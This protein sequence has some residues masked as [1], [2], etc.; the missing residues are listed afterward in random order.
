M[1]EWGLL[2]VGL[3]MS[4]QIGSGFAGREW[5]QAKTN[6]H[7]QQQ[8]IHQRQQNVASEYRSLQ[9]LQ[10]VNLVCQ[11]CHLVMLRCESDA[12]LEFS[13]I[14]S[15]FMKTTTA[16]M[17]PPS[18]L[19]F[20]CFDNL[21]ACNLAYFGCIG[22]STPTLLLQLILVI[23]HTAII[24]STHLQCTVAFLLPS[25]LRQFTGP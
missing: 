18:L 10:V 15:C 4:S 7:Q 21:A 8:Q 11:Q 6:K 12:Y 13:K 17:C 5:P 16:K 23:L 2:M 3:I 22:I 20:T 19:K 24:I 14:L 9:Q 1:H 25:K